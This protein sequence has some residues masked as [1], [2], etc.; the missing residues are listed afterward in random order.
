MSE[1]IVE[2]NGLYKKFGD[3]MAINDLSFNLEA[4]K[5][6]GFIGPNG[7]GKTTTMCLLLGLIHPSSGNGYIGGHPLGSVEAKRL[8]G[9]APEFSAFYTDLSCIDY[10][11]YMGE[12][13]GLNYKEAYNKSMELIKFMNLEDSKDRKVVKFS[14]GMKKKVGLACAMIHDPEVLLLDEPTAN[15]DP[16]TRMEILDLLKKLVKEK[17]MTVLISSHVLTELAL[18]VTDVI[19]INKGKYVISGDVKSISRKFSSGKVIAS[20]D[21]NEL[22]VKLLKD[23]KNVIEIELEADDLVISCENPNDILRDLTGLA[24]DNSILLFKVSEDKAS[25][26]SIYKDLLMGGEQ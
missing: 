2:V 4:G 14:T 20:S 26:D 23:N 13:S 7:A 16:T 15:L 22:L 8:L 5:I 18:I 17:K 6:Y 9:Y 25:L 12:L 21:N 3:L 1:Y 11:V 19:M 10:L 24:H